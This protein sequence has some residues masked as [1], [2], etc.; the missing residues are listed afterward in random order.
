MD[1][2]LGE[3]PM[4]GYPVAGTNYELL[5]RHKLGSTFPLET[6]ISGARVSGLLTH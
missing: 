1:I 6:S 4:S 2:L 3:P 5:G